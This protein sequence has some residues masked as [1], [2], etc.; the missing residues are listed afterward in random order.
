MAILVTGGCGFLGSTLIQMIADNQQIAVSYDRRAA[1]SDAT[2]GVHYVQGDL[3]DLPHLLETI[4]RFAI[5]AVIH[6]AAVS[7][8]FFLARFLIRLS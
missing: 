1:E 4:D 5:D 3:N 2:R 6:A 7:H 8:P